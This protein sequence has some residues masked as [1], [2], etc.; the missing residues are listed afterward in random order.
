M[1]V[2]LQVLAV[3]SIVAGF[4]GV[5]AG[6][7][8]AATSSSTS[9]SPPSSTRTTRSPRSSPPPVPG[10]GVELG[11]MGLSR[12]DRRRAASL[13]ATRFY[14][15]AFEIPDRLAASFPGVHRT[16]LNKYWVDELYDAVFVRGLVARRRHARS[17]RT[18]ASWWT[19]ATAR[20]GAGLGVNGVGLG[21]CATWSREAPNLW[22]RWVVDGARQ[23]HRLR[24]RQPR[25]TRS[26]PSRT[27]SSSTT[28]SA[29]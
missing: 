9:W 3:G 22:D 5:P 11:L 24:P 2:P 25:A 4:L 16:L 13:V 20:S 27:A 19:A 1:I 7:S 21:A 17:T 6:R 28:R 29:C 18:T 23:P 15:G 8:A 10:H 26:G 14:Q 12:P